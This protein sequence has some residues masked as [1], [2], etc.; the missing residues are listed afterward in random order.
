MALKSLL[1]FFD[2]NGCRPDCSDSEKDFMSYTLDDEK[3]FA[4]L[5]TYREEEDGR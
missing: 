2:R 3:F 4:A 1:L 5:A